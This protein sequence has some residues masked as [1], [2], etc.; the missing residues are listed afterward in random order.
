LRSKEID[1]TQFDTIDEVY[2]FVDINAYNLERNWYLTDLWVKYRN[3]TTN[4]LEKQ[5][6]QWEIDCFLFDIKGDRLFSQIYSEASETGEVKGYPNLNDI[7]KDVIEYVSQRVENSSNPILKARYAHLLWKCPIGI[8]HNKFANT[9][10]VNYINAI[11]DYCDQYQYEEHKETPFQ[12][13]RLYETLLA[14]LND[15]KTNLEPVKKLTHKILFNST[16]EF[17]TKHGILND[18]LKYPKLFK[19]ND[20][21]NT[22]SIIEQE[23]NKDKTK[24]DDFSLVHYHIPTAIKIASKTKSDV[25]KWHNETGLAYLRIAETETEEDR[26][27]LKLDN[28]SNAIK[29]FILAGNN[30]K[31]SKAEFLYSELKP[32]VKL[33]TIR[34]DFDEDTQKR[35]QEFQDHIKKLADDITKQK[36]EEVYRTISSGFFFPKYADVI[37]AS[38]NKENSFLNFVTTIHFDK[39]KNISKKQKDI[40]QEKNLFDTYSY[41]MRMSVLPYLHY[42]LIP[43]I[44]SG[45]LTFENFIEFIATKSWIG[46]PHLKYD[47]GGEGK[48]INWIGLL[49]PSIVEF[50]IQIQGWVSSK[51]YKPSFVLCVD[52]LTLKFEGLLRDFCERMSIPTSVSRQ[53]GMQ[54]AYIHNVLDNEIIKMFFNEDDLLLFNYL[55]STD[56]GLNI[57]NNVAHCFYDYEEYHPDQMLLLIAALLRLAKYD[58]TTRQKSPAANMV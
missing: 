41:H 42:I 28:L 45:N 55:F 49:S 23:L 47:L 17:Y 21:E 48:A 9:A 40:E 51:Y 37:K 13:G 2:T 32:K 52:S 3:K 58:Y 50:F 54:E 43:G 8:K 6:A 31:K 7:Q 16:F 15:I 53:K 22:L 25:K 24:S 11:E 14:V 33:P 36:P 57:R 38:E 56:S 10:I 44:K 5:K 29:A 1:I 20:F 39:N 46:K 30:E 18:L 34:I 12:I 35:L 4:E 19:P 26:F 27:W